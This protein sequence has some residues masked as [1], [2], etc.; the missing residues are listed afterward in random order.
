MPLTALT[1]YGTTTASTTLSTANTM[2]S[3]SGG[4]T[5]G[6]NTCLVGTAT[7]Y[8][9]LYAQGNGSAWAAAGSIGAP[10]GHGLL[11]D[12]TTLEGQQIVAGN[13]TPTLRLALST[14]TMTVDAYVR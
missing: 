10:S 5:G 13:W 12:V 6:T 9:E 3:A 1:V 4:A 14:G 2:F 8:G 11:W 7:G